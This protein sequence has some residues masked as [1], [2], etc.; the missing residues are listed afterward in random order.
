MSVGNKIRAG[1]LARRAH[2]IRPPIV[3]Y[4]LNSRSVVFRLTAVLDY[5]ETV[6]DVTER[7]PNV[8]SDTVEDAGREPAGNL[9]PSTRLR[10]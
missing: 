3:C 4:F 5:L 1:G 7:G 10:Y 6:V 9:N 8:M 2:L